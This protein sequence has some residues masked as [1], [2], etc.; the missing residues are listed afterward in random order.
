MILGDEQNCLDECGGVGG[1][2]SFCGESGYC[3]NPSS[4][5]GDCSEMIHFG[6]TI[7]KGY[8]GDFQCVQYRKVSKDYNIVEIKN[9][10]CNRYKVHS[11][12]TLVITQI[13]V[14][15]SYK[16]V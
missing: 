3:C 5:F 6:M 7:Q 4:G 15:L 8:T 2:C 11:T 13:I 12:S 16:L 10:F 14:L 9:R 1:K